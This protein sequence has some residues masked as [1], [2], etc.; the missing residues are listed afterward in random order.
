MTSL[1]KD[2][3]FVISLVAGDP[4]DWASDIW[5]G[6]PTL[7]TRIRDLEAQVAEAR[8]EIER[9]RAE[10][11]RRTLKYQTDRPDFDDKYCWINAPDF[12]KPNLAQYRSGIDCFFT[13]INRYYRN[14]KGLQWAGPILQPEEI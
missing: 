13:Y 2:Y 10:V 4:A 14:E 11:E 7:V 6:V 5:E 1:F 8:Q 12:E 9:L 3:D